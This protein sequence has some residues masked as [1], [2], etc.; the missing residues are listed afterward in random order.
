[1]FG[2]VLGNPG[3]GTGAAVDPFIAFNPIV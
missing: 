1:M 2:L 3:L